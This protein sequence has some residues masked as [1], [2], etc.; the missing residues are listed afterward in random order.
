MIL[1]I[2]NAEELTVIDNIA[3]VRIIRGKYYV[4]KDKK[5]Y[6]T[7]DD[8]ET[9]KKGHYAYVFYGKFIPEDSWEEK[10]T[11]DGNSIMVTRVRLIFV[12]PH[13][14]DIANAHVIHYNCRAE[15]CND[16]GYTIEHI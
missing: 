15:L 11:E 6:F 10:Q 5:L 1:K 4:D 16:Q 2:D 8:N 13:H 3:E 9:V 12:I 7:E 14:A